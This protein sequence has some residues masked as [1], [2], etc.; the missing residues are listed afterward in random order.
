LFTVLLVM[1]LVTTAMTGPLLG[2][3]LPGRTADTLLPGH[4]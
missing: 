3:V 4:R 2:M 1:T